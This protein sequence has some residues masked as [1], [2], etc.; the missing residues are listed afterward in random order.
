MI[1]LPIERVVST[2]ESCID[3]S[4]LM[5]LPSGYDVVAATWSL[6]DTRI[7]LSIARYDTRGQLLDQ[8]IWVGDV[9]EACGAGI[10]GLRLAVTLPMVPSGSADPE[11][12]LLPYL[13]STP[14]GLSWSSDGRRV[15]YDTPNSG[16]FVAD[17]GPRG[18]TTVRTPA[19]VPVASSPV[20]GHV[21]VPRNPSF[22]PIPGDDRIAF[23]MITGVKSCSRSD[24][25]TVHA[26]GGT[27]TKIPTATNGICELSNPAWSPDAQ[28][29]AFDAWPGSLAS[30]HTIYR[31]RADG[32]GKYAQVTPASGSWSY[33]GPIWR[34]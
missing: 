31:V 22:S 25:F 18:D 30:N 3:T 27:P 23:A 28:W 12:G 16:I 20:K 1:Q 15:T 4:V 6:D 14:A 24:I 33:R 9:D 32:S 10:C 26:T 7:A 17:L 13:V 11:S 34:L 5:D 19:L 29:L 2:D 21:V 8:G